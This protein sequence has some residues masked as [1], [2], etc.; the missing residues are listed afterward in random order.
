MDS[1]YKGLRELSD[2]ENNLQQPVRRVSRSRSPMTSTSPNT[3][4]EQ[5]TSDRESILV[6]VASGLRLEAATQELGDGLAVPLSHEMDVLY[7]P[8]ESESNTRVTLQNEANTP[9]TEY[10]LPSL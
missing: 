10:D 8:L 4:T 1:H 6:G 5:G 2:D 9:I 7:D 3:I